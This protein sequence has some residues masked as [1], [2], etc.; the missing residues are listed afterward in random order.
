MAAGNATVV[1]VENPT[2]A[3]IKAA[4]ETIT[5]VTGQAAGTPMGVSL[6]DG[7]AYCWGIEIA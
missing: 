1:V 7:R 6:M 4:M 2:A 3:T 5:A